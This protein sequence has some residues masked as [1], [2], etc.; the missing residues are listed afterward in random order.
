MTYFV[1]R[2]HTH[3]LCAL[4]SSIVKLDLAKETMTNDYCTSAAAAAAAAHCAYYAC[5]M[6]ANCRASLGNVFKMLPSYLDLV[7]RARE[8]ERERKKERAKK[9]KRSKNH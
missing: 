2:S 1:C 3:V 4:T 9:L 5:L 6:A 8:G 7:K